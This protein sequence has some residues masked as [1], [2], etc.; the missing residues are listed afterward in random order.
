[1]KLLEKKYAKNPEQKKKE[2]RKK[3]LLEFIG[4][5]HIDEDAIS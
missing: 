4:K 5:I 2:Q 3:R 1:M